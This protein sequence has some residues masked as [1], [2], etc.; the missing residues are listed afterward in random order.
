MPKLNRL[1]ALFELGLGA[2]LK[3]RFKRQIMNTE[4]MLLL[5][6]LVLLMLED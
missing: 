2:N 1:A 4:L 3:C 6:V 5:M